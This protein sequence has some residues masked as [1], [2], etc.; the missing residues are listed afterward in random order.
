M[1]EFAKLY[2]G[3]K[4]LIKA[5]RS[6]YEVFGSI[7][8]AI[9]KLPQIESAIHDLNQEREVALDGLHRCEATLGEMKKA[10][11]G[12]KADAEAEMTKA[13]A[14]RNL[15]TTRLNEEMNEFR[16]GM[17]QQ[18]Q[19][20]EGKLAAKRE[21]HDR[22]MSRLEASRADAE[23]EHEKWMEG[24]AKAELEAHAKLER[25]KAAYEEF[26]AKARA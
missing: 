9:E 18:L 21:E 20:L 15:E 16:F 4:R 23:E 17:G 10:H 26:M 2:G 7:L 19:E 11:A 25:A 24:I 1:S 14:E 5:R 13:Q 8:E 12:M 3:L 22:V 6:E